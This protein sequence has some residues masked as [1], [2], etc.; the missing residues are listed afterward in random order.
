MP[1]CSKQQAAIGKRHAASATK[2]LASQSL[3]VIARKARQRDAVALLVGLFSAAG[4]QRW[5]SAQNHAQ[6][7]F[8]VTAFCVAATALTP[9]GFAKDCKDHARTKNLLASANEPAIFMPSKDRF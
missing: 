9:Q 7:D 8:A 3:A 2:K 1:T 6:G 4:S 5:A